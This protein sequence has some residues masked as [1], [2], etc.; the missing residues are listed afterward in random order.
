MYTIMRP[1]C[2][3]DGDGTPVA[4]AL[5]SLVDC[6]AALTALPLEWLPMPRDA[7]VATLQAA[8]CPSLPRSSAKDDMEA[9]CAVST[10]PPVA[11]GISVLPS[12]V[13]LLRAVCASE[14]LSHATLLGAFALTS[15]L[16]C[17]GDA[18]VS[19]ADVA[20]L[21]QLLVA[22]ARRL[23]QG[24]PA[25]ALL[26]MNSVVVLSESR[27]S[28]TP[29]RAEASGTPR[30]PA[31]TSTPDGPPR[32]ADTPSSRSPPRPPVPP[33]SRLRRSASLSHVPASPAAGWKPSSPFELV[34]L[35]WA[36]A[37]VGVLTRNPAAGTAAADDPSAD[38]DAE[39]RQLALQRHHRATVQRMLLDLHGVGN[40]NISNL[41]RRAV[42]GAVVE[43]ARRENGGSSRASAGM[44]QLLRALELT[45]RVDG[46]DLSRDVSVVHTNA[47]GTF[48]VAGIGSGSIVGARDSP[49]GELRDL[50]SRAGMQHELGSAS[51]GGDSHSGAIATEWGVARLAGGSSGDRDFPSVSPRAVVGSALRR[52][53]R[54]MRHVPSHP[55]QP[56][57]TR[58]SGSV[59][60]S[61]GVH[62][63]QET[64]TANSG[65]AAPASDL[66]SSRRMSL[67]VTGHVFSGG[68]TTPGSGNNANT[69][70]GVAV[71]EQPS[72]DGDAAVRVSPAAA[73]VDSAVTFAPP[74][75]TDAPATV[76]RLVLTNSTSSND[77]A[78][79]PTARVAGATTSATMV[80]VDDAAGAKQECID[81]AALAPD[82]MEVVRE[83]DWGLQFVYNF[84]AYS[85]VQPLRLPGTTRSHKRGGGSSEAA[86]KGLSLA[87][88]T[89]CLRHLGLYPN[90]LDSQLV[91]TLFQTCASRTPSTPGR[92][93]LGFGQ[94]AALVVRAVAAAFSAPQLR[95][96]AAGKPGTLLLG[97]VLRG[98]GLVGGAALRSAQ[99]LLESF[100]R[101]V[102]VS[103]AW[104]HG[105]AVAV[106]ADGYGAV[107][108]L[109][110]ESPR[111]RQPGSE[112]K[113]LRGGAAGGVAGGAGAGGA[114]VG[115]VAATAVATLSDVPSAGGES[116][117]PTGPAT[118][119]L[120][121][122]ASFQRR[123]LKSTAA[124]DSKSSLS[125]LSVVIPQPTAGRLT[126]AVASGSQSARSSDGVA[127]VPRPV[128]DVADGVGAGQGDAVVAWRGESTRAVSLGASIFDAFAQAPAPT[129][130]KAVHP[131][132]S[133]CC[134]SCP[135]PL[136]LV[137]AFARVFT[138][139]V[140]VCARVCV[141]VCLSVCLT[142]LM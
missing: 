29:S 92:Q 63:G 12:E 57:L 119:R 44:S 69:S 104:Y 89:L 84:Y 106:A 27:G 134:V 35:R 110:L 43:S 85:C 87:S 59:R 21:S 37:S 133:Y 6:L 128:D 112:D 125:G 22:L 42:A 103:P 82:T 49:G 53:G 2:A 45:V 30:R 47:Q 7:V 10:L 81:D 141:C 99:A 100:G 142:A 67:M 55:Y 20:P 23:Q 126:G 132:T 120:P 9:W 46:G 83:A 88:A 15:V 65:A 124:G 129:T 70:S 101:G 39:E 60:R 130:C 13:L 75:A 109:S 51:A 28:S 26:R 33:P 19:T 77:D 116:Q 16:A 40:A 121:R 72:V 18:C 137:S 17:A 107:P 114:A 79:V 50:A 93:V 118:L 11:D 41:L 52:G 3:H 135:H 123:E 56:L 96:D 127:L 8:L 73:D 14:S 80:A 4:R 78:D 34:V 48:V 66:P 91:T 54:A 138:S 115:T 122:R 105:V 58:T 74:V 36:E 139:W 76:P 86:P 25:A 113:R 64:S 38:D 68:S 131:L 140:C 98:L 24:Q 102:L 108:P 71:A 136:L 5:E 31:A 94:F 97:A 111:T 1:L 117:P 95:R 61:V 62:G 32:L 90:F